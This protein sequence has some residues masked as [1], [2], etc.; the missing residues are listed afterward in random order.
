MNLKE[1]KKNGLKKKKKEEK[2]G[3]KKK[4]RQLKMI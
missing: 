2:N 3:K 4:L 1:I